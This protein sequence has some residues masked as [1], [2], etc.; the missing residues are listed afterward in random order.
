MVQQKKAPTVNAKA[1]VFSGIAFNKQ[2]GAAA[3]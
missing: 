3:G 1:F 2:D